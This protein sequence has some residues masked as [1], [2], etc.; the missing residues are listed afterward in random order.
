ML[1]WVVRGFSA[2]ML[3]LGARKAIE[4]TGSADAQLDPGGTSSRDPG[5][6]YQVLGV[7]KIEPKEF[8]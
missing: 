2:L 3:Y 6:A 1:G 7:R 8:L 4:A 5:P